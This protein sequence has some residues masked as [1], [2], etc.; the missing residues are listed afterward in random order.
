VKNYVDHVK[1]FE[2]DLTIY[3]KM[4]CKFQWWCKQN[5]PVCFEEPAV[6]AEV[7]V[8]GVASPFPV[9][10]YGDPIHFG[11][12]PFRMTTSDSF[13]I[14]SVASALEKCGFQVGCN[15]DRFHRSILIFQLFCSALLIVIFVSFMIGKITDC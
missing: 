13:R 14:L 7:V 5:A 10:S 6:V 1:I 12:F 9:K 8:D 2:F 11:I 4:Y 15:F 3:K